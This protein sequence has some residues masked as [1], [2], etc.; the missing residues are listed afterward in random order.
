[1]S[2]NVLVA[3]LKKLAYVYPYHQVI[4][5]YMQRAGYDTAQLDTLKRLGLQFDFYLTYGMRDKQLDPTWRLYL[6]KGF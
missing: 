5:F 6:P 4:G 1:M 2:L 3:T